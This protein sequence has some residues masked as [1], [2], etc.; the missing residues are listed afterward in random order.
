MKHGLQV[1]RQRT[2]DVCKRQFTTTRP[3]ARY[4]PDCKHVHRWGG[5]LEPRRL[6][7]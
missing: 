6:R 3:A 4:C 5:S 7:V 2:C 1:K